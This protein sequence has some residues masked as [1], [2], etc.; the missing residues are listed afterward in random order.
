[1]KLRRTRPPKPADQAEYRQAV[2]LY[3]SDEFDLDDVARDILNRHLDPIP[4]PD[5]HTEFILDHPQIANWKLKVASNG[6]LRV[7]D[8]SM[9]RSPERA[10]RQRR[11]DAHLAELRR[12]HGV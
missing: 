4:D 1:M 3:L 6:N 11:V 10:E 8:Y 7:A 12:V 2:V 5:A 9:S